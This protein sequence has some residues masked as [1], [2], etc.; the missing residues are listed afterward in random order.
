[1]KALG[2]YHDSCEHGWSWASFHL[3]FVLAFA[4]SLAC[5]LQQS[6]YVLQ[7]WF[8]VPL[9]FLGSLLAIITC[10]WWLY[11][12]VARL[13][14]P[15]AL[16]IA[17]LL[18]PLT[19]LSGLILSLVLWL[20]FIARTGPTRDWWQFRLA[21]YY[22]GLYKLAL[23]A[24]MLSSLILQPC[25]ALQAV[26]AIFVAV[27]LA[28]TGYSHLLAWDMDLFF[29]KMLIGTSSL[30]LL[31]VL[32]QAEGL[33][34]WLIF[35]SH[36]AAYNLKVVAARRSQ[37]PQREWVFYDGR[38]SLCHMA[39]VLILLEDARSTPFF[40][41]FSGLRQVSKSLRRPFRSKRFTLSF[42]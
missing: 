21:R 35:L 30:W 15:L 3:L 29:E 11:Q 5:I 26:L 41:L 23:S 12:R 19:P 32:F 8:F 27:F 16:I 13:F 36:V 7:G 37:N 17:V 10:P 24:C 4:A 28:I 2:I 39:V 25:T 18:T 31:Y 9:S 20:A 34:W 42:R 6:L 33:Q 40:L 22:Y 38:C 1:M 14:V